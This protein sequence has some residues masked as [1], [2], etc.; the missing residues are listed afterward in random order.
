MGIFIINDDS[1]NKAWSGENGYCFSMKDYT[2]KNVNDI[3]DADINDGFAKS[4]LMISNGYIP[5]VKVS[6]VE[7]MRAYI[8]SINNKKLAA[9]FEKVSDTDYVETFWKYSNAYP[10]IFN[11][12]GDFEHKYVKNKIAE[13]CRENGIEYKE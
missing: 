13:W 8:N 2:L 3:A 6:D 1:I 7:I 11:G 9:N 5:Y 12:Y 10:E 4:Q